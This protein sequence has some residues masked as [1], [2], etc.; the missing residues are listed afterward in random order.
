MVRGL[1]LDELIAE[2]AFG[3]VYRAQQP[4]VGREVAV[5]IVRSELAD[6]PRFI[7]NFEFE[8]QV[9]AR[10]E[11]PYIVPL[12]DYWR[13]PGGAYLVMRYLRGGT[14]EDALNRGAAD[15]DLIL[16]LGRN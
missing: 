4:S 16:R 8:A 1:E 15:L 14:I 12:Y 2:G 10:L 6:D 9:V 7:R 5:K 11:H 3:A 13:E